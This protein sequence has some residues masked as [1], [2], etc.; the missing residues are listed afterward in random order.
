CSTLFPKLLGSYE[1]ELQ[2]IMQTIC[3]TDY[4]QI[5][6]VGCAEG[7]YAVGLA[8]R[9]PSAA[10][11]AFDTDENALVLCKSMACLNGVESRVITGSFCSAETL[12]LID[13]TGECLIISDCEGYEKELFASWNAPRLEGCDL[14][15]EIH[16]FI[17][18]NISSIIR[19]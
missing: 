19:E 8:M 3:G 17:D 5:I 15:I 18:I 16:D 10:V 9:I 2:P 6:D 11:Y 12:S 4:R 13:F 1:R 7:Y 14:L